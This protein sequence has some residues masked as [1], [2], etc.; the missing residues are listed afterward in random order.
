MNNLILSSI[1]IFGT[2]IVFVNWGLNNA[3][4]Q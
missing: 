1:L 3:Y 2:I 4:P